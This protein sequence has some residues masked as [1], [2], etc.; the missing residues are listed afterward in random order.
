MAND[1]CDRVRDQSIEIEQQGPN[2][3][4]V[5]LIPFPEEYVR[6]GERIMQEKT[7]VTPDAREHEQARRR[8]AM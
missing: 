7:P 1:G 4:E 3:L 2:Q 5:V 8:S 6:A